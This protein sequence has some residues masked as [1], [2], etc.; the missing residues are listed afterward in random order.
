MGQES[1]H[2]FVAYFDL[3]GFSDMV[4][5]STVD[6]VLTLFRRVFSSI[7]ISWLNDLMDL[8]GQLVAAGKGEEVLSS[9]FWT[10]LEE[11]SS[12]LK[13]QVVDSK[14]LMDKLL[15]DIHPLGCSIL[16]DSIIIHSQE[17]KSEEDMLVAL[18]I[19]V[20]MGRQLLA[21][22]FLNG[23]M[24]RGSLAYGEFYVDETGS[25]FFGKAFLEA[26]RLERRQE[27]IGC[28]FCDSMN[29]V[30]DR[31]MKAWREAPD[32][33]NWR[34]S[35]M[36]PLTRH[37]IH[38]YHVPMKSSAKE[39]RFIVNWCGLLLNK[40]KLTKELFKNVL[41][42]RESVDGKYKNTLEYLLWWESILSKSLAQGKLV[43]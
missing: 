6:D 7:L 39:E 20:S 35:Y 16:S 11:I 37:C 12:Q 30:I 17:V 21:M 18:E 40:V 1:H 4:E 3:L 31:Y 19:T 9:P 27:W 41:T 34:A 14:H 22:S 25:V 38:K 36:G 5:R 33:V 23:L 13:N 2:R 42:G 29:Q 10:C 24:L 28:A 32:P 8:T 15:S 26:I 43:L